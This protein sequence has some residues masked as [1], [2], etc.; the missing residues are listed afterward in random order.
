[1]LDK[2]HPSRG[3]FRTFLLACL[4]HHLSH[5]HERE[6]ALKRGGGQVVQGLP[7][8]GPSVETCPDQ[9]FTRTWAETLLAQVRNDLS[10]GNKDDRQRTELL[11]PFLTTNGD[12]TTYQKIGAQLGMNEGAVKVAVHRLRTRFRTQLREEV[13]QTLEHPT[14]DAVD[15]ELRE[16]LAALRNGM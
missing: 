13:A 8:D 15:A 1:M 7:D 10:Q 12:A 6:R 9:T 5:R 3:R 16:L 11:M 14:P 4:E 2:A